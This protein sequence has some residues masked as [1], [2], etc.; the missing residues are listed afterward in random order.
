MTNRGK[1]RCLCAL[2]W[3]IIPGTWF[4]AMFVLKW[5]TA[6]PRDKAISQGVAIP[7]SWRYV[8]LP[9]VHK[10]GSGHWG[11]WPFGTIGEHPLEFGLCVSALI[12][13]VYLMVRIKR[14]TEVLKRNESAA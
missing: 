3:V 1:Y 2:Q 6:I 13:M 14:R 10:G 11:R 8:T 9:I 7:P 4:L 12:G 5:L